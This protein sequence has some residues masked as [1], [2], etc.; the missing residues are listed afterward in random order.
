MDPTSGRGQLQEVTALDLA[1][2]D[3]IGWNSNV[4]VLANPGYR[5]TSAQAFAASVPEPGTWAMMLGGFGAVGFAMRRRKKEARS[6][7]A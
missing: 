1:A 6:A 3:A 2:F 4:N 7:V 5:F